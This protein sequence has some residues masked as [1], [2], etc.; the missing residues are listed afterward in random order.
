MTFG[1]GLYGQLGHGDTEDRTEPTAISSLGLGYAPTAV[2]CGGWHTAIL[3]VASSALRM[4]AR[5]LPP[6]VDNSRLYTCGWGEAGQLGLG[7][8]FDSRVS[9]PTA[10][11]ELDGLSVSAVSCGSR[12]T[13]VVSGAGELLNFGW[14]VCMREGA[15]TQGHPEERIW[16]P[17]RVPLEEVWLSKERQA[18]AG[19]GSALADVVVLGESLSSGGWHASF[20]Y[21][22]E[23]AC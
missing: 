11:E 22:Y 17:R 10:V 4:R 12:H 13:L 14:S 23:A 8:A 18:E 19:T 5:E 6:A 3:A 15:S 2:A 1:S 16:V 7:P 9:T 21:Q 20:A